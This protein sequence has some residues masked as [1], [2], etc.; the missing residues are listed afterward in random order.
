[1]GWHGRLKGLVEKRGE[2][3]ISKNQEYLP[4]LVSGNKFLTPPLLSLAR[5]P[6]TKPKS[7]DG[8]L[9]ISSLPPFLL[10]Q[11]NNL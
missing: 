5:K 11:Q 3:R 2:T 6:Q 10:R 8:R 9:P 1:L 4:S 7:E